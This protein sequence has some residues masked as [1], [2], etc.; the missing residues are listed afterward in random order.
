MG[1]VYDWSEQRLYSPKQMRAR[2]E[3]RRGTFKQMG[4]RSGER[5]LLPAVGGADFL[6]SILAL[7][8]L[9]IS[10]VPLDPRLTF[11]ESKA[12]ETNS[13]ADHVLPA[14][15][16]DSGK[17]LELQSW[18]EPDEREA[19]V[20]FTTGTLSQPRGVILSARSVEHKI[21]NLGVHLPRGD[22]ERTLCVL[23]LSFGHGLMGNALMPWLNG[24]E[25]TITS[26]LDVAGAQAFGEILSSRQVSFFSSVPGMW[27]LLSRL[28]DPQP[29]SSVCRIF[30]ASAPMGE[31]TFREIQRLFPKA[32]LHNVYGLTEMCSWVSVSREL[33]SFRAGE[34]GFPVDGEMRIEN[35]ELH[36]RG[37]S[38]MTGYLGEPALRAGEWFKTADLA[39]YS[40]SSGYTIQ[41]RVGNIVNRGGVKVQLEEIEA[42]LCTHPNVRGVL[43]FKTS[44]PNLGE[45]F[46][47]GLTLTQNSEQTQRELQTWCAERVS[48]QRRPARWHFLEN[49][50]MNGRGK[51]DRS[52]LKEKLGR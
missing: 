35:G 52:L 24:A 2:I 44:D 20:L 31:N 46:E 8:S 42:L 34:I 45:S 41:G 7:W 37:V 11:A 22:F 27:A 12:L 48:P 18:P 36:V 21:K 51:P 26:P 30:C 39:E 3:L 40:P 25:L 32:A 4:F 47:V 29:Q 23:P 9:R 14:S 50:P 13:K 38:R 19:L 1:G 33:R 5:V 17:S 28:M 16:Q 6:A 15:I 10:A 43:A 49:L